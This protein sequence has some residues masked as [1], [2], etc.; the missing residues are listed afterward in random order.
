MKA[1]WGGGGRISALPSSLGPVMV[2]VALEGRPTPL[3]LRDRYRQE[4]RR[5]NLHS[6]PRLG[7]WHQQLSAPT[8]TP[9][10]TSHPST[11]EGRPS[12]RRA[13][14]QTTHRQDTEHRCHS[15]RPTLS[16]ALEINKRSL[17]DVKLTSPTPRACKIFGCFSVQTGQQLLL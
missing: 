6:W 13:T 5:Q 15:A 3:A 8:K 4:L 12:A 17:L 2:V 16:G 7:Y 11:R 1:R 9:S 10:S 14:T